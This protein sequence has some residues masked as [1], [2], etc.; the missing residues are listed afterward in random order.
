[1]SYVIIQFFLSSLQEF[2]KEYSNRTSV[3]RR[4]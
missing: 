3:H 1:M 4:P 2:K